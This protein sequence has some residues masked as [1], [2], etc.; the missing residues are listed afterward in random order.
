VTAPVLFRARE[1]VNKS[2][3]LHRLR[4]LGQMLGMFWNRAPER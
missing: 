4:E 3:E 1:T 2:A